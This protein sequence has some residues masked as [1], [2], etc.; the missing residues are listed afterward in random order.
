[1][2]QWAFNSHI[3]EL[4]AAGV[5]VVQHAVLPHAKVILADD[6]VLAAAAVRLCQ[7]P[8]LG[9]CSVHTACVTRRRIRRVHCVAS[10]L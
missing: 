8:E 4:Q 2:A 5:Q 6:R 7:A 1:M 9:G 3:E 10:S